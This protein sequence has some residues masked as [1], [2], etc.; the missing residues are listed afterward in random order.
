MDHS[1]ERDSAANM[2]LGLGVACLVGI[3]PAH[4]DGAV[5]PPASSGDL[6]TVVVTG[7]QPSLDTLPRKILD[8]PQSVNVIGA[9]LLQEQSGASLSDAL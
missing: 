7:R 3:A 6:S 2:A 8:T 4:A 9:Q 1:V 5:G